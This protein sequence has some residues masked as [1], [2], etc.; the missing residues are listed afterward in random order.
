MASVP[1]ATLERPSLRDAKPA[2]GAARQLG[3]DDWLAGLA[4]AALVDEAQLTPKPALVDRRGSGAH[5]DLDLPTMLRSAHALEATFAALARASRHRLPSATLRTELAQIGRAGEQAMMA[6][7][8]GSNAHRGAIWSIGLLVAS[9]SIRSSNY[10]AA[11][12][13]DTADTVSYAAAHGT[14]GHGAGTATDICTTAAQIACFPDR[15]A[16]PIHSNGERVR[17]RYRV[18]GA[19]REAQEGFPHVTGVGLPALRAARARGMAEHHARLDALLAIMALLD[20]TCLLH[21]A[22]PRGLRAAQT[23]ARRALSAGGTSSWRGRAALAELEGAL[24]ALNASPGGSADLLA[25]T[26]FIDKLV[27]PCTDGSMTEWNI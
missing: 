7:T 9:A 11:N 2:P 26:L 20:D 17:K 4:V 6:A 13:L 5:R 15:F 16:A 8:D 10:L 23:G 3:T 18:G 25:A 1:L 24:L 14:I 27:P 19:M 12:P 22:G 21:R